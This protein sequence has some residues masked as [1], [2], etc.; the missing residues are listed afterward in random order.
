[1]LVLTRKTGEEV[2]IGDDVVIKVLE[3]RGD[4][5]RIGIDA[6]TKIP[7]HRGEVW[8][9]IQERIKRNVGRDAGRADDTQP[10][11]ETSGPGP[12]APG[13]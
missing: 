3:V 8:A 5:V 2:V 1:M 13:D 12:G 11:A 6:P 7:V 10:P 4:K 9:S